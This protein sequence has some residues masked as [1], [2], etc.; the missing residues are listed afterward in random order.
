MAMTGAVALLVLAG[1]FGTLDSLGVAGRTGY[2]GAVVLA[3]YATGA[4]TDVVLRPRLAHIGRPARTTALTLATAGAVT[5]VV[6]ALN[7]L[8]LGAWPGSD[9][10][11]G[12]LASIFA[13]AAIATFLLQAVGGDEAAATDAGPPPLLDR[14]PLD[15]RGPILALSVEDHYV[16][17]RTSRGEEMLLMRLGDAIR[18]AAPTNGLQ[19]HRSHWV[20]LDAV[21]SVQREG[22]RA[23]LRMTQGGDIPA[24]RSHIPALKEAGLLPR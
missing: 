16:R 17:V 24:S 4:A 15:K 14:L 12:M 2:W 6:T 21:A 11:I 8:L 3:T 1:P 5:L 22:D 19:V 9:G 7:A 18:E 23:V 10:T 20:A 13:A